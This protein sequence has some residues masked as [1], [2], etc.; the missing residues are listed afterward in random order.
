[1][2]SV[3][4]HPNDEAQIRGTIPARANAIRNNDEQGVLPDFA[5]RSDGYFIAHIHESFPLLMDG[6]PKAAADLK[7][8]LT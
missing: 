2:H 4:T 1:M 7:P 6:S 5:A 8:N 3:D